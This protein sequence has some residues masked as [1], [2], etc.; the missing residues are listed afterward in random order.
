MTWKQK[1][2]VVI[3][4]QETVSVRPFSVARPLGV[5]GRVAAPSAPAPAVSTAPLTP[6]PDGLRSPLTMARHKRLWFEGTKIQELFVQLQSFTSS[7]GRRALTCA[8]LGMQWWTT[9]TRE[10]VDG[11]AT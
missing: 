1:G 9:Q 2:H 5:F 11:Q 3:W 7:D 6:A 8:K 4:G 10:P